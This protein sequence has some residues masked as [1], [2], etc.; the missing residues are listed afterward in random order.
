MT[1]K[2]PTTRSSS[3]GNGAQIRVIGV[4]GGGANAVNRMIAAG[5]SGVD[6]IAVNTDAQALTLSQAPMRIRIGDKVTKGLGAGGNAEIG[7]K[8][9]EESQEDLFRAVDGADMVF[10]TAGMGGGTGT[11]AAPSIAELAHEAGALTIGVVTKPF[12]FEGVP[13]SKLADEGVKKL[14]ERVDTLIVIPN[15]RLLEIADKKLSLQEAFLMADD[16]LR[17][18]IQ[19]ISEVITVPG[20]INLD[21]ADVRT[22]MENGGASLMAVGR[23]SGETRAVEAAEQAI[24]SPLLDVTI[25]G[26]RG[27]LFNITG[28]TD[29][30]L[31][32]VNEAAQVIR[33]VV[34]PDANIM[35]GA[36]IDAT[37]QDEVQITV[38]ACGF[39]GVA[40]RQPML[41]ATGTDNIRPFPVQRFQPDDLDV[42]TFLRNRK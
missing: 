26:A 42:P 36:V 22:I 5:V 11:G 25:E 27:V 18:G 41:A 8:A 7:A 15:D 1:T 34:H 29:L 23:A 16:V 14:R 4:G 32:E 39:D 35:F 12:T 17:Q 24:A 19:G 3:D 2:R 21:F 30:T 33:R 20:L 13:R 31:M 9:A 28:G 38:V 6:F 10:V 40:K 37:M